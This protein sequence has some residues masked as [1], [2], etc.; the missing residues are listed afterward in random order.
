MNKVND[1]L[2]DIIRVTVRT[3]INECAAD[4]VANKNLLSTAISTKSIHDLKGNC[5]NLNEYEKGSKL[6]ITDGMP[7]IRAV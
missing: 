1:H 3:T 5:K 7:C 2:R 4:A 6:S